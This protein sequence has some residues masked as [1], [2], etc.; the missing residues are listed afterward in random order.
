LG[1]I[2]CISPI[3]DAPWGA[4]FKVSPLGDQQIGDAKQRKE[5]CR[6][7]GESSVAGKIASF[8]AAEGADVLKSPRLPVYQSRTLELTSR[9][10]Y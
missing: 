7:L 4:E 5:L 9:I 1:S 10:H 3:Y 2:S 8:L 6:I